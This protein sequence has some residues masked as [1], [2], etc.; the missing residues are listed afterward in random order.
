[1]AK[2]VNDC[3]G[4]KLVG[5]IKNPNAKKTAKKSTTKKAPKKK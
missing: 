2:T 3:G 4:H 5:F 1:M